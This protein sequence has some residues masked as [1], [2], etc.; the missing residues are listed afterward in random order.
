VLGM[1]TKVEYLFSLPPLKERQERA[2]RIKLVLDSVSFDS[3]RKTYE[4]LKS[5]E[6]KGIPGLA[7]CCPIG[8]LLAE[9]GLTCRVDLTT[10]S[11]RGTEVGLPKDLQEFI[12]NYNRRD[13]PE[14]IVPEIYSANPQRQR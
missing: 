9:A 1:V 13:Y 11:S 2:R 7:C 10:V 14:L 3:P 12:K 8:L 5:Y 6:L 4:L